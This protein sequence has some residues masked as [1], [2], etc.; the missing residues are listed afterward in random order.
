MEIGH[1]PFVSH[2]PKPNRLEALEYYRRV[3][4]NWFLQINLYEQVELQAA[5]RISFDKA[6]KGE[7]HAKHVVLALILRSTLSAG[8]PVRTRP[9]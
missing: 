9:K 6:L 4:D 3:C 5:S 1:V 7:Y 8:T 2:Q